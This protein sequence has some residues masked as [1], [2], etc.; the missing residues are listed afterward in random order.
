MLEVFAVF[1]LKGQSTGESLRNQAQ[2]GSTGAAE[3]RRRLKRN[4]GLHQD[5]L[6]FGVLRGTFR[7]IHWPPLEAEDKRLG[8]GFQCWRC[9]D[10]GLE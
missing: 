2:V 9:Q 4:R 10:C 7:T 1:W 8:V 3:Q 5:L 6:G